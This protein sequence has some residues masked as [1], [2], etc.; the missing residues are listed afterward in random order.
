MNEISANNIDI[1]EDYLLNKDYLT[2]D[3]IAIIESI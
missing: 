1:R 2:E 3:E